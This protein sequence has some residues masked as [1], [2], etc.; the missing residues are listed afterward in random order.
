[1]LRKQLCRVLILCSFSGFI[2]LGTQQ[3]VDAG[4]RNLFDQNPTTISRYLGSYWTRLTRTLSPTEQLVTYTYNPRQIRRLF[5]KAQVS[6][7]EVNFKNSRVTSISVWMTLI[8]EK[9]EE[10]GY[11]AELEPLFVHFFGYRP[12][13]QSSVYR[14]I[15]ADG[16]QD[17]GG[18]LHVNAY[19]MSDGIAM[20]YEYASERNLAI[21]VNFFLDEA[22][23]ESR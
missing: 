8:L 18:T 5:P 11:P 3:S 10:N 6:K 7:L 2:S 1:M 20:A 17:P 23:R 19:C 15:I 14:K 22:C 12:S 16:S 4:Q 21:Y 13:A 9:F